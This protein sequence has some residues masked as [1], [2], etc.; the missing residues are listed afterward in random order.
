MPLIDITDTVPVLSREMSFVLNT[1]A[2]DPLHLMCVVGSFAHDASTEKLDM[3][4]VCKPGRQVNGATTETITVSVLLTMGVNGSLNR[5]IP[6]E[7][8]VVPF[9]FVHEGDVAVGPNNIEFHGSVE[10][11][12][13]QWAGGPPNEPT[14]IDMVFNVDGRVLK[15][16]TAV[17]IY[18]AHH[19]IL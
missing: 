13:M 4:T 8:V 1:L 11:P 17:P 3:K 15:N 9:S 14:F 12:P 18:A 5:L 2:T 7:N 6:L 19:G 16:F 10:V